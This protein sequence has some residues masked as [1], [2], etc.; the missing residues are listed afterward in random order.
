M[1]KNSDGSYNCFPIIPVRYRPTRFIYGEFE[2]VFAVTGDAVNSEDISQ[3]QV[4]SGVFETYVYFQNVSRED[5][6]HYA[7]LRLR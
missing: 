3:I 7:A 4:S 6:R 5:S 2:G 1:S